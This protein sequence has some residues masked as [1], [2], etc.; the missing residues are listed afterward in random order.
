MAPIEGKPV[1]QK[2]AAR[3]PLLAVKAGECKKACPC[4]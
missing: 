3:F 1:P 4:A 2:M